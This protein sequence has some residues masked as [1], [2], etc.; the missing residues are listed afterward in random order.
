[1]GSA[2][3]HQLT[4]FV[5]GEV[6]SIVTIGID[7][8]KK[9]FA[10][11]GV[12]AT[13]QP[14][15]VRPDV[16]PV[17]LLELVGS[18]PP[19]NRSLTPI[20]PDPDSPRFA[21]PSAGNVG[22]QLTANKRS[23]L[24]IGRTRRLHRGFDSISLRVRSRAPAR[25]TKKPGCGMVQHTAGAPAGAGWAG[26]SATGRATHAASTRPP[27]RESRPLKAAQIQI[28]RSTPDRHT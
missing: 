7:L 23:V 1:M 4:R 12:D 5:G 15:L 28:G 6:M 13:G 26:R 21:A 17:R 11:H 10:V 9:V 24:T 22:I 19:W 20:R 8:A 27:A 2:I 25:P 14:M 16:R 18:L 3:S